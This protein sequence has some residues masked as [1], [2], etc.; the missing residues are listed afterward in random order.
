MLIFL[1]LIV[2][3]K[4]SKKNNEEADMKKHPC[5]CATE[6][7]EQCGLHR[8]SKY[9]NPWKQEEEPQTASEDTSPE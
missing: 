5:N 1:K 9:R 8:R 3:N 7:R 6:N 4:K 2:I